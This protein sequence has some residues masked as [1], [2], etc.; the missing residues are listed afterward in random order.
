M[1]KNIQKKHLL[2]V[3]KNLKNFDAL[4]ITNPANVYFLTGFTGTRGYIVV[5]KK[6]AYFLTDARYT[7]NAKS[8]LSSN[9]TLIE[10]K[11]GFKDDWPKFLKKLKIKKI[12]FEEWHLT[13]GMLSFYKKLSRGIGVTYKASKKIVEKVRRAKTTQEINI[14]KKSQEINEKVLT[15]TVKYLKKKPT[16]LEVEK[17]IL[18]KIME[19]GGD[20]PSFTP[21]V[22]FGD[23]S[24]VPHHQN[25]NRKLKKG[26]V[27][28]LDMGVS[29]KAYCSDMTRTFFTAKPT[30]KQIEV[31][32]IVLNAQK[33]GLNAIHHNAKAKKVF[34]AGFDTIDKAGYGKYF[35]HGLGHGIGINIHESPS[36][37][38]ES[39]DTLQKNMLTTIEPGIY[40]PGKFGIRIEDI[41]IVKQKTHQ[42]ITKFKKELKDMIILVK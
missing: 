41:A 6:K 27:V 12:G 38:L 4:F 7:E 23:H 33:A 14:I 11:K 2:E 20:G 1:Q 8:I 18:N 17:F 16:E 37:S 26:H 15:D 22:A 28:L 34:K 13:Y 39:K 10:I 9:Y 3:K 40:L 25:T 19:Y 42:N 32:E 5:T 21:I 24:A 31:Y 30:K 36:L 29:Y 35:T